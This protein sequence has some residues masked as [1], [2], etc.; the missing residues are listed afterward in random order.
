MKINNLFLLSILAIAF[1]AC[2]K[3]DNS[4]RPSSSSESS[5]SMR[6]SAPAVI[7]TGIGNVPASFTQ[8]VLIENVTGAP[9]NRS[10]LN[11]WMIA[12]QQTIRPNQII[13][14]SFHKDDAMMTSATADLIFVY[15]R[16]ILFPNTRL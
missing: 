10:P 14:A 1:G 15:W 5:M 12:Q 3:E 7:S 16:K 13:T 4:V 8:K 2:Q 11:D 6:A 9:Y